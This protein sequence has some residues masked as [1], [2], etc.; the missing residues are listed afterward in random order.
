MPASSPPLDQRTDRLFFLLSAGTLRSRERYLA[1]CAQAPWAQATGQAA[2]TAPVQG[3]TQDGATDPVAR[4]FDILAAC[5]LRSR[6]RFIAQ[7]PTLS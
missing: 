5:T 3:R 7:S 6:A 1:Q 2:G 4:L